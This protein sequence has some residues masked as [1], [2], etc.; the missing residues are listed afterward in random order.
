M[1][2]FNHHYPYTDFHELNLDWIIRKIKEFDEQIKSWINYTEIKFAD[3]IQWDIT[4]AYEPYSIVIAGN[5][6]YL[7]KKPVPAGYPI[8]NSEYWMLIG[9]FSGSLEATNRRVQF[10]EK[11]NFYKDKKIVAYGDSTGTSATN[12]LRLFNSEYHLDITNRCI[13]GTALTL[14]DTTAGVAGITRIMDASDLDIFDYCWVLFGINDWMLSRSIKDYVECVRQI[15]EKFSS[16]HNCQ[17]MFIFPWFCYRTFTVDGRGSFSNKL[18]CDLS[19]YIDAAIDVCNYYG[20]KYINM[21]NAS[22]VNYTNYQQW[23]NNDGGIYV[24][25]LDR[26]GYKMTR[27]I[28][29]GL[30]NNGKCFNLPSNNVA[31]MIMNTGESILEI[32]QLKDVTGCFL[33]S[34]VGSMPTSAVVAKEVKPTLIKISGKIV[35]NGTSVLLN[36]YIT[37]STMADVNYYKRVT[38]V[39]VGSYFEY[40]MYLDFE[41]F[42]ITGTGYGGTWWAIEDLKIEMNNEVHPRK[43]SWSTGLGSTAFTPRVYAESNQIRSDYIDITL[44][45]QLGSAAKLIECPINTRARVLIQGAIDN[46]TVKNFIYMNGA[47]YNTGGAINS[48]ARI[49]LNVPSI[50]RRPCSVPGS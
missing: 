37:G 27:L 1:S 15:C 43:Y 36:P 19:S 29:G 49:V 30:V 17:P 45:S 47:I 26:L 23:L 24:H 11:S 41:E 7:S 6:T 31:E 4:H 16:N 2:F 14:P 32:D 39:E 34:K 12:M 42:S 20:V 21:F 46:A 13:G 18:G 8:T 50:N 28:C 33:T 38:P 5:D 40:V 10:L 3:P 44:T 35:G 25:C 48:G 22:G 9:N